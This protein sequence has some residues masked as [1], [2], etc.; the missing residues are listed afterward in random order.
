MDQ[1]HK[2]FTD[3]QIKVLFQLYCQ[4]LLR[5][6]TVQEILRIGKSQLFV[7]LKRYRQD[8]G[9]FSVSYKR[10]T[11]PRLSV[12]DEA[13]IE[14]ALLREQE[15]VE[16]K[17]L[18]I[19]CYNYT[20]MRDRLAKKE[21][22]VSVTTIINRAK[23]LGCY[24]PRKKR[25]VHDR[26][27]LTASIGALI[28][29]DASTHLWAPFAG[30]KWVLITSID[31]FSRKMLFADFFR[32]ETTWAH[33]QAAQAL[34]QAYGV[35]LRY[36]VDSLRVF[37]FVQG[38]D[39]VWRKHVLQT[40]DVDT[41]WGKMM[42]V[43]GV[44]VNFALSPQAKGKIERPYGWLQDRIV[45]TCIYENITTFEETRSVLREEIDRYNNHQ[46]HSTT[47]EVPSIRFEKARAAGNSLL[48]PL[49]LPKPYTS[50]KDVF[51]LRETRMV[52]GYRR[53]SLFNH[54]IEVPNVP[55]REYV[56]IHLVPDITRDVMDIRIWWNN[57]MVQSVSYPLKGFRVHF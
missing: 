53:I 40:D 33:I 13:E 30:E 6:D 20:A 55:L 57:K 24:K 36:Y 34:M 42:R 54:K 41:Q 29:H 51:C 32:K 46:V 27:V 19:S 39:S 18:P 49:S 14:R 44:D 9:S 17:R 28:Q 31:D 48:R 26:E 4:G 50:V 7:L 52:D 45:R 15:I 1:L 5:R 35:P 21:I 25:K 37:R 38:R 23:H 2:R 12:T 16:D 11:P 22:A 43:L 10:A 56:E 8:P 47:K 3:E